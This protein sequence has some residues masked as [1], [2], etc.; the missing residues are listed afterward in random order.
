VFLCVLFKSG[1]D[2]KL[3]GRHTIPPF[4]SSKRD[5]HEYKVP[6]KYARNFIKEL[7]YDRILGI[8]SGACSFSLFNK[9]IPIL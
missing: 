8:M 4:L 7:Y 3:I 1:R 6:S 5:I 9:K 2:L